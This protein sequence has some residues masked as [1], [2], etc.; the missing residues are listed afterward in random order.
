MSFLIVSS[1]ASPS[2]SLRT[3]P[4]SDPDQ[5]TS[6][7][8][9]DFRV[10]WRQS[11]AGERHELINITS[12][13]ALLIFGE[14]Q[15]DEQG[16]RKLRRMMESGENFDTAR[17]VARSLV[18]EARGT[19]VLVLADT[20]S[21]QAVVLGDFLGVR[22]FYW[23]VRPGQVVIGDSRREVAKAIG[24]R[25]DQVAIIERLAFGVPLGKRSVYQGVQRSMPGQELS[26]AV[27][28]LSVHERGLEA[29]SEACADTL[30]HAARQLGQCF[31]EAVR[32]RD[33]GR[34]PVWSTLSGGLDSRVIS[35]LLHTEGR[36]PDCISL[37][38]SAHLDGAL[39]RDFAE[40][41]GIVFHSIPFKHSRRVLWGMRTRIALDQIAGVQGNNGPT[42]SVWSGDGGS[43]CV[44]GV[45]LDAS[46]EG[47]LNGSSAE[48]AAARL[49]D[50][51]R[52][53]I[54]R[55]LFTA[56]ERGVL[57][58]QVMEDLVL[59]VESARLG[60]GGAAYRFLL[61]NDQRRHLDDHYEFLGD[62]RIE[63]LLPFFDAQVLRSMLSTPTAWIAKHRLY[64]AWVRAH[65][66]GALNTAWQHYPGHEPCDIPHGY[67]RDQW[68]HQDWGSTNTASDRA[69]ARR[70]LS[71][72]IRNGA[73]GETNSLRLRLVL[74]ALLSFLPRVRGHALLP[75]ATDLVSPDAWGGD[76]L[77]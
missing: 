34:V 1:A 17:S 27:T 61:E 40:S 23:S 66:Q 47:I 28:S 14:L 21:K 46:L 11:P 77:A 16:W 64:M 75:L 5:V 55:V 41:H 57:R 74:A 63:Y 8:D 43:V 24:A 6:L 18:Q 4:L 10:S 48:S 50:H 19:F 29:A 65:C 54:S 15:P 52:L 25:P 76:E 53:G 20:R 22:P 71:E 26:L 7:G 35:W 56:R 68:T 49:A 62:H 51:F 3:R 44:G 32:L 13:M 70:H 2:N 67:G 72:W 73:Q 9:D 42:A 38:S 36:S 39:A 60:S 58:E 37:L 31:H 45:Y 59:A 12:T 30:E 33:D 69:F